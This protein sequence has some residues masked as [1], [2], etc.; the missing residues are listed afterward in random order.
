MDPLLFNKLDIYSVMEH[1]KKSLREAISSAPE[2]M[3][4]MPDEEVIRQFLD[5]FDVQVPVLEDSKMEVADEEVERDIS[6]DPR[7]FIFDRS[8][9][10]YVKATRITVHVPFKGERV[11]FDV[12]PSTFSLS[13]P[14]GVVHDGEL[15]LSYEYPNDSLPPDL[16]QRIERGVAEVKT[17]LDRLRESANQLRT[18]MKPIAEQAWKQRRMQFA[19]RRQV[20]ADL[21]LP[22][23]AQSN[24]SERPQ[25][26]AVLSPTT[27]R[28]RQPTAR[29]WQVFVCHASEDKAEI[30]RPLAD[31][32]LA[33]GLSVWFDEYALTVGDSLRQKIDEGLAKSKFGIVV[34]SPAFFAKHW[35]Q[36]ELNGLA[37]KEV[38]G[39]KVILPVW[40]RVTRADVAAQ[41]P[42]L[43]DRLAV[44]TD[45]GLDR[46][47]EE[48]LKATGIS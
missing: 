12:Q 1:Q 44:S 34:L 13:P 19:S 40:H 32:L 14:R 36:Q 46:V 21:G 48:L 39:V 31:A 22:R 18:E 17:C 8:Q 27:K 6:S 4:S 43:A 16:K 24:P 45:N 23:R 42:I 7:R 9:P 10:F 20:V 28:V 29:G 3:A 37:A 47:V 33:R 15:L 30:A 25:A 2:T 41:S 11:F 5:R 26:A 38:A 35:P